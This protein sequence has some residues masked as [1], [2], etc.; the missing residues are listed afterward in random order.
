[1][2]SW[3]QIFLD[4]LDHDGL[5]DG[6][7]REKTAG[8]PAQRRFQ[9]YVNQAQI[10]LSETLAAIYPALQR[11]V[12]ADFF[13]HLAG[14]YI[15]EHPL[16]RAD[17]LLYGAHFPEFLE[18]FEA[19]VEWPYL[20]DVARLEW[21]CHVSLHASRGEPSARIDALRLCP[22]AHLLHSPYPIGDIWDFA[23]QEHR[24]GE[25]L[26]IE[27]AGPAYLLIHRP[28]LDVKV[29]AISPPDWH[30]LKDIEASGHEGDANHAERVRYWL[31]RQ[32][33]CS[34][35]KGARDHV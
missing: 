1:M 13:A 28:G 25:R 10:G 23:L 22:H 16:Q 15:A 12:G 34:G 6:L 29:W 20:P 32:V 17:L 30:W 24:E 35:Q 14:G 31:T 21:A 19:L 5:A 8:I 26:N 2:K 4:G 33:I 3:R 18:G 7:F 11:L 9:V 27:N